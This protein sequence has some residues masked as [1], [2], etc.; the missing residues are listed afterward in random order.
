[1]LYII[2]ILIGVFILW[3]SIFQAA[4][5]FLRWVRDE[6]NCIKYRKRFF[7]QFED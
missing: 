5:L 7:K 4:F 6:V 3:V 2:F 1:M